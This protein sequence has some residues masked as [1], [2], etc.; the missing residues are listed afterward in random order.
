MSYSL[1][2]SYE[3][4]FFLLLDL[5]SPAPLAEVAGTETNEKKNTRRPEIDFIKVGLT[6]GILLFHVT[7]IYLPIHQGY[8]IK[9][10]FYDFVNNT[11]P[12]AEVNVL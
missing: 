2:F 5:P 9:D 3:T 10:P 6:W 8:Y 12:G 7:L 4:P 11:V 1:N